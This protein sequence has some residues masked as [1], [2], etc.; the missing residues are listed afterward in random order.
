MRWLKRHWKRLLT[1]L[2]L[3]VVAALALIFWPITENLSVLKQRAAQYNARIL[4]DEWG[5]PHIF[6]QTDADAAYGLAY[7]HA[8]DDFLTI[9]KALLAVRGQLAS[10][11]GADAAPLDYIVQLLRVWDVVNAKY[12][13]DLR[14]ET[15][16]VLEAYAD[17][18]NV[19]AATHPTEALPGLFPVTGKDIV[20]ESVFEAPLLF[21]GL[22]DTLEE[23]YQDT[24]QG[25]LS[26]FPTATAAPPNSNVFAVAPSRTANGET[27]LAINSHQ[28]W[29][30]IA[31]WYEV[32]VH[33][34]EGWDMAGALFPGSPVL[35]Q[36][37]NHNLGW[38][39]TVN[40]PDVVDVFVLEMNLDNANQYRVNGEWL[41][42][43][44][45]DAQLTV[46]LIG[47]LKLPVTRE[48]LWS[49][50]GPV[51]RQPHGVYAIRY[52][53]MERI[54]LW[55][56]LYQMNKAQN[57]EEWQAAMATLQLP[58]FNV[59]YAD[60][61]GNIFY[62]Y[63]ALAP[64]RAEG[65]NWQQYLPGDT[66]H[67][68]WTDYLSFEQLPQTLNPPSGFIQNANSPP[69]Q[70][71]LGE[72]NPDPIDFS[73]TLGFDTRMSNRAYRLLELLGVDD[74]I[75]AEEFYAIKYD[76]RYSQQSDMAKF[77]T[78]LIS[79][80]SLPS[81]DAQ[82]GLYTILG[83]DFKVTADNEKAALMVLT[84]I[85]L[86]EAGL[87]NPSMLTENEV[88]DA[89]LVEAFTQA[90][91]TLM[92][93]FG[94][95]DVPW[96]EVN[97]LVRG[98]VDLPLDGGPDIVRAIYGDLQEDGRLHGIVGDSYIML[99][100]WDKDGNVSSQSIHQFGSATLDEASPHYA[101]QAPLFARMEMKPVWLDEAD[102][103][104]H[105]EREYRP[106]E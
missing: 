88:D 33:S 7:A 29:S 37:H 77:W 91:Q 16:A 41:T 45:R 68:L 40:H 81:A 4:R 18:L 54:G 48:T 85:N 38:A 84:L 46:K 3:L 19:Y 17:G 26:L 49:I 89:Q 60:K 106:G 66:T 78:R 15:R 53:G 59:G 62:A 35:I 92:K 12:E 90:A 104:A 1:G 10:V 36:G 75:T 97:R 43:E 21:A 64:V 55:E 70:T 47:N 67:T 31:A 56:Q 61:E 14:P 5:V 103:R 99:V 6:G 22:Q 44:K 23:L 13:T 8:E 98:P 93:N 72:G 27:F 101:D 74:S 71:T 11:D 9:Q 96:G 42:L 79:G 86:N 105:L 28:P 87:I 95:T 76:L 100:A 65:Y 32:H 34:E 94:R 52:S 25:E 2:A 102:I 83:W 73:P 51:V 50:Y 63:N 69:Y 80:M 58:A 24:R 30:G 20:A 82:A 39:F 57:L